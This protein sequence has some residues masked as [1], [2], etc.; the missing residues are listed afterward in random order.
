MPVEIPRRNVLI[1]E[2][3]GEEVDVDG[4]SDDLRV[5][6]G[7]VDPVVH[8]DDTFILAKCVHSL[9]ARGA[10]GFRNDETLD[11]SEMR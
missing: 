3:E 4:E 8:R 9:G 5:D 6:E 1:G 10:G 11:F 2:H 7:N